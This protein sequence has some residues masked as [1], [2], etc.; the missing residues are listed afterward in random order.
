MDAQQACPSRGP[1]STPTLP[2]HRCSHLLPAAAGSLGGLELL[3][4]LLPD[5]CRFLL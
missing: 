2:T 4:S 3:P 1:A 5:V